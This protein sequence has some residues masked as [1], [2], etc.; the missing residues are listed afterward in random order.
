MV[1]AASAVS[2]G[3]PPDETLA[4]LRARF[5]AAG[6]GQVFRFLDEGKVPAGQEDA[7]LKQLRKWDLTHV[8]KSLEGALAEVE[9]G[10]S[11]SAELTPPDNFTCLADASPGDMTE[12]EDAGY[13]AIGRGEVAACI[14][15]GGQGT[16][17]GFDGPKGCYDIGL[18]SKKTLFQL[19]VEKI[20]RLVQTAKER[21]GPSARLPFLV[22]T[23]PLNDAETRAFFAERSYFGMAE[24]DVWFFEQGTLPCLTPEGKIIMESAGVVAEGPDGN[25]GIYPALQQSGCLQRLK[26]AGV[27]SLH[28]FSVDNALSR[29]A[30]PRFIGYCL[31]RNA[32]CGNKSVW[33]SDPEEKVGVVAQR[34]GRPV[35]VEYSELDDARK[36]MRDSKGRL[37]FGAGNICNHYFTVDFLADVVIPNM[38]TLFHLAHKKISYAGE[39]GSTVKPESNNGIKLEA[40]IFDVFPM[41]S[42]MAI[43]ETRREEEFAPV[44]NAPGS[45]ADSPD[46]ARAMVSNQ[47]RR[48]LSEAG[49][50]LPGDET[51]MLE[52]SPLVS[53]AG[54]GI[55][56]FVGDKFSI[57]PV[58]LERGLGSES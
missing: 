7:L 6:Q 5:V 56:E 29:P 25:G 4:E 27:R 36:T 18:P 45:P 37:V 46:T 21:G 58:H 39:D 44:K 28:V 32:D 38:A 52:V 33:K 13:A 55:K 9:T 57:A 10:G 16:R 50:Q 26:D 31:S 2:S 54:E 24:E 23:S 53:Y 20:C 17:L 43:L 19:C 22:M 12:W 49:L 34:G 30:D 40:F 3:T 11:S 15:A 41:S 48:W 35:V 14:L 1:E 47:A 51:T 42:R 8:A